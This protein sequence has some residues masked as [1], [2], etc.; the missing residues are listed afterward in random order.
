M[1]ASRGERTTASGSH[2][3][4]GTAGT[5][6]PRLTDDS[7]V[8]GRMW[9]KGRF[10][11]ISDSSEPSTHK[12]THA[13]MSAGP[14]MKFPNKHTKKSWPGSIFYRHDLK[15]AEITSFA[16]EF[17]HS[18]VSFNSNPLDTSSYITA[19]TI[20]IPQRGK[21]KKKKCLLCMCCRTA[22]LPLQSCHST[23]CSHYNLHKAKIADFS[24]TK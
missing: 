4:W 21:K 5:R 14:E 6:P 8:Q 3:C 22:G 13:L 23:R 17:Q 18:S 19:G 9:V 2:C 20:K 1:E 7:N 24:Y 10:G 11:G 16:C 12:H 15:R